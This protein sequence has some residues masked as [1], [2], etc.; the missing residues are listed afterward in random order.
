MRSS[1]LDFYEELEKV[2]EGTY[3]VV[4]KARGRFSNIKM[5]GF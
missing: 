1:K 4:R 2:G 3:G 5:S